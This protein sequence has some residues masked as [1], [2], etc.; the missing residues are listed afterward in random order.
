M[1][2]GADSL[3]LFRLPNFRA[4]WTGQLISIFGDR[5]TYLALLALIAER[6]ADPANPARE[7]SLIPVVSFLPAILFAPWIGA[8]VDSWNTRATLIVSDAARGVIVLAIIPAVHAGG[9][10]AGF[11]LVF[12]LYL[13][14]TFF[15]PARSAIL[16]D[17]VPRERLV[18]ANSLATLA[19]I[20]GTI[21]GS[22]AAGWF[23]ERAG[24]R[25]GFALDAVTYFVSVAAL[26]M[27]RWSA[28]P[29]HASR[30][31]ARDAYRALARDVGEGARIALASAPI[32]GSIGAM[33][34]L[35]VAGGALHVSAPILMEARG[36]GMVLGVGR[37]VALAAVGMVAGTVLL[38]W[39]GGRGSAPARL[40]ISL[41]GTGASVLLFAAAPFPWATEIAALLAGAFVVV[42]L[43]TTESV[44][45]EAT[46]AEAR[47]RIFALRDFLARLGVLV[48]ALLFGWLVG[49]RRL[50]PA[51]AATVSGVLLLAGGLWGVAR[52]R[53]GDR[54][55]RARHAPGDGV[56][57]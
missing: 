5:F 27:I 19:G 28:P 9:L 47:A 20:L 53:V 29:E 22:L 31:P 13:A 41:L 16:P 48:S 10:P 37:L 4:L 36:S 18:E 38:A 42:L 52:L 2:R 55:V 25:L 49:G 3:R 35:W 21:A 50:E 30:K 11:A 56:P 44:L 15:L 33:A 8:L 26:A 24:W 1:S 14:N 45:Q 12:V 7:L 46:A 23:V 32:R 39:R 54:G 34:L 43:V 17:L 6:A 57:D 51:G 40:A